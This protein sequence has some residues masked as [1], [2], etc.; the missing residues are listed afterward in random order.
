MWYLPRLPSFRENTDYVFLLLIFIDID[1]C[2]SAPPPFALYPDLPR[3]RRPGDEERRPG[4]NEGRLGDEE[5]RPGD[6]E[7]RPGDEERRPG[8]EERRPGDE[9][10]PPCSPNADCTNTEGGFICQCPFGFNGDGRF[11]GTGCVGEC[12]A[13]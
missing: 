1:E 10:T 12:I 5:R 11:S 3:E 8:D 4:D 2:A 9:A 7:R 6:K 13:T